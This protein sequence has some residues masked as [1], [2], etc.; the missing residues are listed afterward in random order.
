MVGDKNVAMGLLWFLRKKYEVC[1]NFRFL[2]MGQVQHGAA[3]IGN[4]S[5]NAV[6]FLRYLVTC[7]RL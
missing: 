3:R 5:L 7:G 4:F 1:T 6:S 2:Q